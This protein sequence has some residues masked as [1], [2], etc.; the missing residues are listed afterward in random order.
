MKINAPWF[1]TV[2]E[3]KS[4]TWDD[5]GCAARSS[6]E[7]TLC[8][9]AVNGHKMMREGG[10]DD[11]NKRK[12]QNSQRDGDHR[13]PIVVAWCPIVVK[14]SPEKMKNLWSSEPTDG[15]SSRS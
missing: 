13:P 3:E 8:A 15:S 4:A 5:D 11:D 1:T 10:G 7:F 9:Q 6:V 14:K 2:H 12:L